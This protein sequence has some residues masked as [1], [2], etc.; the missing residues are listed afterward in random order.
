MPHKGLGS[1]TRGGQAKIGWGKNNNWQ[2]LFFGIFT[3]RQIGI[4]THGQN[5]FMALMFIR[6]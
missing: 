3:H 1:G 6:N 4:F 5:E 2:I